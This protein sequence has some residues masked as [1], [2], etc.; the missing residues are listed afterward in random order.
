MS[1]YWPSLSGEMA[2][3]IRGHDWGTTPLGPIENWP[4]N[5]KT[6]VDLMLCSKQ[7]VYIAFGP[8]LTS[9]Y[10]DGY[11][12]ILGTKHPKALGKPY[13]EV[14]PEIWDES[15]PLI[16]AVM[17]GEAQHFVDHLVPLAGRA[18]RPESWFTFSWTPLRDEAG[19]TLGFYCSAT[20][21]TGQVLAQA[22]FREGEDRL[23]FLTER[24]EVGYW[25]KEFEPD[26]L[27]WSPLCRRLFGVAEHEPLSYERFLA[28]VHPDDRERV[29]RAVRACLKAG[30]ESDYDIEYR[31]RTPDG[32]IR[33][34]HSKGGTVFEDG[35][36]IRMAGISLDVTEHKTAGE[37]LRQSEMRYRHLVE[38]MTDGLFVANSEGRYID[39][40]PPGCA[41]LQMTLDEVLGKRITDV[42]APE[43]RSRL[44]PEIARFDDGGV[45]TS[46]WRFRRKDG[47]EF[48][49]EVTGRR[50]PNGNLQAVL[51]DISERK[52]AEKQLRESEER[53]RRRRQELE[54]TLA[55]IP[56]AV[57]I[58]EDKE[59]TRIT[60]NAAGYKLLKIP[61]GMNVSKSA[62]EDVRPTNYET[63]SATGE[64]LSA[65][66]LPM[67]QAAATGMSIQGAEHELR[68]AD[69][70]HKHL[71]GN[72]LPL[73]DAA[74]EVRGALG[75]FLDITERRHQE[76]RIKLLLR[77]VNHRS[78]NMLALVQAI[79]R[80]TVAA[81]PEDFLE[82]FSERVQALARSQDLLVGADWKGVEL[83]E[84]V[85]LQLAHFGGLIGS[86]I[87]I[88]GPS[89]LVSASAAQTL[90]MAIHELA[91][92]AGKY[93]ALSVPEGR[94]AIVWRLESCG[95]GGGTFSISWREQDGP[96]V[97]PPSRNG[98]GSI[99]IGRL[100]ESSLD[101][102]VDLEFA[103]TGLSWRLRCP[104][105]G[106]LEGKRCPPDAEARLERKASTSSRPKVL[107]VED[108]ALVAM[109]IAHV[110][111]EAG[112]EVLGPARSVALALSLI[113]ERGCD[114]AVLDI[115]LSGET[116]EAVARKLLAMGT[117]FVTLSGYSRAQH[118]LIFDGVPALAKPLRPELLIAEVKRCV[119]SK[120]FRQREI[121]DSLE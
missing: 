68:F 67:Q 51:R 79:A 109:E 29:D 98:F 91:T 95:A 80:Q 21:T 19:D 108:E 75:A 57:L 39:V 13:P 22:A 9:L 103:E 119:A 23:R 73:F 16:D 52:R 17:A 11:I 47:S 88:E 96:P 121:S 7:P 53:E 50:L 112:F 4:Q 2:E 37:A 30:G 3:C 116:S 87:T 115:N 70:D 28:A 114:A 92:N 90:G 102:E 72:A 94:V 93:G 12:P 42:I 48:I 104:A 64:P 97:A 43:E 55:V 41:M 113:E 49:G 76:E 84:L 56:V 6:V 58:A 62:P 105:E 36:P 8:A 25:Y 85:R 83:A 27:E 89:L 44:D 32:T 63:Y 78:K 20:E 117:R 18:G 110:L 26:R 107:V 46:E 71:L 82:S 35:R 106:M 1:K 40:S 86:G 59:C 61:E 10:N 15:I 5:L 54:A 111:S 65:D 99:V 81:N 45:H 66:Q 31:S 69:G 118:P 33:W 38:Q 60:G 14:W 100:A 74:G 34:I 24:A 101:A 120:E 77:E